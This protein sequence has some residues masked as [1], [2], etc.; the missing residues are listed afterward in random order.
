MIKWP[1]SIIKDIARRKCVI[2][3]GAGISKNASNADGIHPKNWQELLTQGANA[4]A[5]KKVQTRV[6]NL[7]KA[8]DYL[9]TVAK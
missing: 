4:L 8:T 2:F 5:S 3:L 1:N 6:K 9:G 7:I